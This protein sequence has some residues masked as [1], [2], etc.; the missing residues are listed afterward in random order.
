LNTDPSFAI[1]IT[2]NEIA[3]QTAQENAGRH[4]RHE[5]DIE[6]ATTHI[7]APAVESLEKAGFKVSC[8]M[9]T[10]PKR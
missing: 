3:C 10:L 6:L 2:A 4:N 5:E 9:V 1:P 7:V 8:V